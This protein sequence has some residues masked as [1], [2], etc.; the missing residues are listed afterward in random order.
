VVSRF[1][2][3][4]IHQTE[5]PIAGVASDHPEWQDRFYFNIHD[6]DGDFAL[7]TGLGAFP[8][9]KVSQG[10]IFAAHAGQHYSYLQVRPLNND[11]EKM[12]AGTLSFN[13]IEPL[14]SWALDIDDEASGISGSLVFKERCPLYRFSPIEWQNHGHT[15]VKQMHYT[16]AGAYEGSLTIGGRTFTGLIGMRDRSWGIRDMPRVPFWIWI[17]AQFESFCISAWLWETPDGEVIH[18]DGALIP[19]SG[20]VRPVTEIDHE[21]EL[22]PGTKRPAVGHFKLTMADGQVERL[23]ASEIQTIFLA[24]GLARWADSD[25]DALKRA[26]AS[27]FG[28]DQHCRFDLGGE[29]GVG[30]VEYMVTGGHRRY[31]IPPVTQPA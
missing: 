13:V 10:Y 28:F 24:P 31:G 2:E 30:I 8:N 21:L 16:Q 15:V 19:E 23:S 29:Q 3:F 1:D 5:Q 6:R 12:Q 20:E 22:W 25:S 27:A 17:S 18:A 11:R 4:L 9:R 14:K 26:D 7:I